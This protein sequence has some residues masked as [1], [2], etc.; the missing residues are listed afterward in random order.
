[1]MFLSMM[2]LELEIQQL[3][4]RI[5]DGQLHVNRAAEERL[6][7]NEKLERLRQQKIDLRSK[8]PD[9]GRLASLRNWF[10]KKE[11]FKQAIDKQKENLEKLGRQLRTTTDTLPNLLNEPILE[12][13]S[14]G[15]FPDYFGPQINELRKRLLVDQEEIQNQI[16]HLHL[17]RKLGEFSSKL[18]SGEA[19]ALCGSTHHP[20]LLKIEDVE[21]HLLKVNNELEELKQRD[22]VFESILSNLFKL[23]FQERSLREQIK[24][25]E[26]ELARL[27]KLAADHNSGFVWA[28]FYPHNDTQVTEA[29]SDA[30]KRQL[31]LDAVE[32]DLQ[33]QETLISKKANDYDRFS[34]VVNGLSLQLTGRESEFSTL[35]KRIRTLPLAD[36]QSVSKVELQLKISTLKKKVE[37]DKSIYDK[38]LEKSS[39]LN[40]QKIALNERVEFTKQAI[41]DCREQFRKV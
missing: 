39:F 19:C 4:K 10:D 2:E 31:D 3:R 21:T 13:V 8:L 40:N 18:V 34:L 15:E 41:A 14:K 20:V 36:V 28:D 16:N 9:I 1:E 37:A 26:S 6:A 25:T 32:S 5:A 38:W 7:A 22:R 11:Q 27:T 17:Q 12:G 30:K 33:I 35:Q 24:E 23:V 29:F